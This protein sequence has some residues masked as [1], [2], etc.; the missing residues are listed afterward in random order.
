MNKTVPYRL[1]N[2]EDPQ[3]PL[4]SL[5]LEAIRTAI[6]EGVLKS[7]Q[8]LRER[9]VGDWLG[10]SRTPVREA[11]RML[12]AQGVL[13]DAP[14]DGVVVTTL[15]APEVH[16][17]YRTWADLEATSARDAALYA[18]PADVLRLQEVHARWDE[19]AA[20]QELGTLN[21]HFHDA[22]CAAAHNRYLAR[23]LDSID[24]FLA[25][26]GINTYTIPGRAAEVR[27]EHQAI[28]DAIVNREPQ[29]AYGA[30]HKHIVTAGKLR[31][32]LMLDQPQNLT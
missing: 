14:G 24:D 2:Q 29:K 17:L 22:I 6:R 26:L 28:V 20:P 5:V 9:D 4:P 1:L 8:R 23:A 25:L 11:F 21:R 19:G 10:V 3:P 30:A 12:Q 27:R 31:M 18:R 15:A 32:A 13:S 7:G 16:E